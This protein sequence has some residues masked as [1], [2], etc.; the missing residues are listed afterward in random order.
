MK[1]P[2]TTEQF[3]EVFEKYNTS[4]FPM[5]LVFFLLA[6]GSFLFFNS[7]TPK[8]DFY[9]GAFLGM[10]WLWMGIVYHILFFSVIN[11][12]AFLFGGVFI[13]QGIFILYHT[14]TGR[15]IFSFYKSPKAITGYFLLIFSLIIY[16]LIGY[17]SN[18]SYSKV[19]SIGLPCPTTIY[20]FGI[21]L[22][23]EKRFAKYLLII[24]SGWAVI[25]LGAAFNFGVYQDLL[26]P[27]AAIIS[28]VLLLTRKHH[29][30]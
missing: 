12:A 14:F 23:T 15:L 27:L 29:T 22:L 19:I 24:P 20:T 10:I 9:I 2:F 17:I 11:N 5:Q 6:I 1:T 13:L 25:G 7:K 30:Q 4:V 16:P 21:F 8:K 26:L 28:N 18:G 3:F